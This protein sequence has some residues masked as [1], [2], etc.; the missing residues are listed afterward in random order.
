MARM[1][2]EIAKWSE[3]Q[4]FKDRDPIWLKLYRELRNKREWR[5]L[6]GD[7][8][9]CLV[10]VWMLASEQSTQGVVDLP[11]DDVAWELRAKP[12]EVFQWLVVIATHG[13]ITM[14]SDGEQH[15]TAIGYRGDIPR[16]LARGREEGETEVETDSHTLSAREEFSTPEPPSP[17]QPPP[18]ARSRTP[19]APDARPLPHAA[20]VAWMAEHAECLDGLD[21]VDQAGLWG[22]FGPNGM[23]PQAWSNWPEADR[24]RLLAISVVRWKIGRPERMNGRHFRAI[25]TTVIAEQSHAPESAE[26][27]EKLWA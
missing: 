27:K 5:Q 17:P 16:A 4:H 15:N 18:E 8:A 22:L 10:D 9:K 20:L 24:P 1:R 23:D 25:I 12:T 13:F 6:T 2:I 19:G 11:L 7:E 21:Y 14:I 26:P 3:F